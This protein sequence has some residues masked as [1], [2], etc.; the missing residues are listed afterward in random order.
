MKNE[1]YVNERF[2]WNGAQFERIERNMTMAW[3]PDFAVCYS[4]DYIT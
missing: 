3:K 1:K 4:I 2:M